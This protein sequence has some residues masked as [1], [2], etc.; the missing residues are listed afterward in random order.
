MKSYFMKKIIVVF[1][2]FIFSFSFA[3]NLPFQEG[4][5][6]VC[7]LAT[8]TQ[9]IH[10]RCDCK[11][12]LR[13]GETVTS[14]CQINGKTYEMTLLIQEIE[15]KEYYA[16][17][18]FENGGA[19]VN[20]RPD[21]KISGDK[22][23]K[24]GEN[25]CFFAKDSFDQNQDPLEF[26][27]DFGDGKTAKGETVCH[28]FE[29]EGEY[30]VTLAAFDG[31]ASSSTTTIVKIEKRTILGKILGTIK[32]EE[33]EKKEKIQKPEK[34]IFPPSQQ[35]E[36]KKTKEKEI[37]QMTKVQQEPKRGFQEKEPSKEKVKGEKTEKIEE[38][39]KPKEIFEEKKKFPKFFVLIPLILISIFGASFFFFKKFKKL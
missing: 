22:E 20:L 13:L 10:P 34:E 35:I 25:L 33:F 7:P 29:K 28:A 39:E 26:F 37:S 17:L 14:A 15:G 6:Y 1:F 31:L 36:S 12:L 21:A 19:A 3:Q 16:I 5:V 11:I 32:K 38:K 30:V 27:W 2:F 8:S 24:I 23:G 4:Q 18:G 9:A